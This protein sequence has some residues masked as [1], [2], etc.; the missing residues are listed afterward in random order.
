MKKWIVRFLVRRGWWRI[1]Y[2]ISPSLAGYYAAAG[3]MKGLL[4]S[5]EA[6]AGCLQSVGDALRNLSEG[7]SEVS[8][9]DGC[10]RYGSCD[11][12]PGLGN[13]PYYVKELKE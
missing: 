9:C 2:R 10:A 6:V 13:C 4:A 11:Y 8:V 12:E 3:A 5:M 1:A 7:A